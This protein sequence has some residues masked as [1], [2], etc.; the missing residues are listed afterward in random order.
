MLK[1]IFDIGPRNI[2]EHMIYSK[3]NIT[4]STLPMLT[5]LTNIRN[6][7]QGGL[8]IS[9]DYQRGYIWSNDYKDQ[10]ILSIILNYPIG[11]IVINN[12]DSSNSRNARQEVVDG[13]Q[14]LTTILRFVDK[15]NVDSDIVNSEDSWYRL[16]PKISSQAKDII[17]NIIK[18]PND[19]E[20]KKMMKV[21]RLSYSDLPSSIKDAFIAYSIPVYTMQSADPAQIRDYF[22]VLQNQEKLRAGEIINALPDNPL[23]PFFSEIPTSF[24]ERINYSN[25]KRAEFE[26]TYYQVIGLW[27]DAI[28]IN[29]E[30][31]KT[32][33]FVEKLD[34]LTSDQIK[35][36]NRMNHNL[37]CIAN[38]PSNATKY[39]MSKRTLKLLLGLS[40]FRESFFEENTLSKVDYICNISAKCSAF[41]SSDA[42]N[43]SLA[44]YFGDEFDTNREAFKQNLAPKY[45]SLFTATARSK[46]KPEFIKALE[47]LE[48]LYSSSIPISTKKIR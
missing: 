30:D 44:K 34:R 11:N 46:T 3:I 10:L 20:V 7:H 48:E 15:G 5:L 23:L 8:D 36:V 40:I 13:K 21:K 4:P 42:E 24:L 22:K 29:S 1:S 28:Q 38:M 37:T 43:V 31:K 27:F 18:N 45:R 25:L 9:P 19:P 2:G 6:V 16:S 12:L 14:R 26:K 41:N 35:C 32:I 39:R 17:N 47:I 33:E